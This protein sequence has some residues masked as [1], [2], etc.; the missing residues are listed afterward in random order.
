MIIKA[1]RFRT[2]SSVSRLI[3][4]LKN[5]IDNDAVAFLSG[6]AADITDMHSD[7]LAKRATYSIRHWIVSPNE[8]T[9]R[10]Q[11]RE[12]VMMLA[13][14]FDFEASRAVIIEHAKPRAAADAY[15]VHW[16]LLVGEVDP[17]TRKAL[18]CSFDRIKHELVA[19][20]AEYKFGHRFIVGA[21]TKAV[22][23][24]L[25]K[26]G[27]IDVAQSLDAK[28]GEAEPPPGE[29]FTHAQH[30]AKKRVGIDLP[31][32]RQAVK[33]AVSSARTRAELEASLAASSLLVAAGD[34]SNTWVVIDEHGQFIGSLA[35]LSGIKKTEIDNIMGIAS[36]EPADNNPNN[37]TSNPGRGASHSQP[38]ATSRRPANAR[39]RNARSDTG[40]NPG[41][42]G[43]CIEPA[44]G[45]AS[46]TGLPQAV[47]PNPVGWFAGLE[48]HKDKLSLL[49]G[50]ANMLAMS[51]EE[52]IAANLWEMEEQARFDFNRTVPVFAYSETTARLRTEVADIE[53]SVAKKWDTLFVAERRLGKAKRPRWWH[54]LLGIAFILERQQRHLA[55]AV[56]QASDELK[57]C[58][59]DLEAM[60]SKLV[61]QELHDKER[62]S[63]LVQDVAK[64]KEASGPVLK[65]LAAANEII[66]QNPQMALCGLN[67]ILAQARARV[68]DQ[69]RV[70][71]KKIEN[72][73]DTRRFGYGP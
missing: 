28:L 69:Q 19:R 36:D 43:K 51:S 25:R 12:V 45:P 7:A 39:S 32:V 40:E 72:D 17:V 1:I 31:A 52:R 16:H 53:K 21:H 71:E 18:R 4:H 5:G 47:A 24:G 3:N 34:R 14:E 46:E 10:D 44:R 6:T 73:F 56:Q 11:M 29:A 49:L 38:T 63:A 67:F 27:A 58:S 62:H 50:K 20:W 30:Q 37:R 42:T 9:T 35:R 66:R 57:N 23:A 2:R 61:R 68:R 60:N 8:A 15:N 59:A 48:R 70:E 22:V 33:Q 41:G 54:Y 13:Q 55:S 64:R 65:Q 26:R